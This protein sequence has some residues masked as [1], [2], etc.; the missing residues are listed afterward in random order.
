M[1][2]QTV[3]TAPTDQDTAAARHAE[4]LAALRFIVEDN[5]AQLAKI[6]EMIAALM[7]QAEQQPAAATTIGGQLSFKAETLTA[8]VDDG[9]VYWKIR[10]ASFQKFGVIIW[11]EVLTDAGINPEDLNPLKTHD[12]SAYVAVCTVKESGQ[13]KKVIRLENHKAA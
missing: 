12:M 11:P 7:Q 1:N 4:T 8:T 6:E 9:K 13:P 2:K 10:G 3:Q 5:R